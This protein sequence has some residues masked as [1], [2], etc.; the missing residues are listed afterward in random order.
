VAVH[1][2]LHPPDR[3]RYG[4]S[5]WSHILTDQ[6]CVTQEVFWACVK[7]GTLPGRGS[8]VAPAEPLPADL[9]HLLLTRVGL[10]GE[11]EVD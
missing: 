1:A 5:L 11:P 3:T 2:A 8:Q 10:P 4:A 9:V 7:D 6:L